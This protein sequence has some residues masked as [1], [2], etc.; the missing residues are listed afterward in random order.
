MHAE[1]II[2]VFDFEGAKLQKK[3]RQFTVASAFFG[4]GIIVKSLNDNF[5][6]LHGSIQQPKHP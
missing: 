3:Q 5:L 2:K 6:F 1:L 4:I